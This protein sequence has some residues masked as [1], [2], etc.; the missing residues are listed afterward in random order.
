MEDLNLR[1]KKHFDS[2]AGDYRKYRKLK[3]ILISKN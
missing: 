2:I 1:Q 3:S